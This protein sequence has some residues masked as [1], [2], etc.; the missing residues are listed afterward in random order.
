MKVTSHSLVFYLDLHSCHSLVFFYGSSLYFLPAGMLSATSSAAMSAAAVS[1]SPSSPMCSSTLSTCRGRAAGAEGR[2]RGE[3]GGEH[4]GDTDR[5][6]ERQTDKTD[7]TG[8][9]IDRQ[10]DRQTNRQVQVMFCHADSDFRISSA[11]SLHAQALRRRNAEKASTEKQA[12]QHQHA[13][14]HMCSSGA[15]AAA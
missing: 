15:A 2:G 12:R 11:G 5:Q 8:R 1:A 7:E 3:G 10:A 14:A 6:T 13:S 9:H 4:A